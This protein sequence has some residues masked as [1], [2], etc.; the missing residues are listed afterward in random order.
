M[1]RRGNGEGSIFRRE[2]DGKWVATV[3]VAGKRKVH[4]GNSRA[5]VR[6]WL[7]GALRSRQQGLLAAGSSPKLEQYLRNW[8]ED[9]VRP[10][11]RPKTYET[12]DLNVRRLVP[13]LGKARLNTLS[14][15]AIQGRTLRS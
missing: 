11:V 5:E 13:H 15:A 8:L 7:T 2:Q 3:S 10:G 12:Y 9:G 1:A 6:E 14:P 4:Y